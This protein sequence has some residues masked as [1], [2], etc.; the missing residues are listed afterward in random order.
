MGGLLQQP[1]SVRTNLQLYFRFL[2]PR[3]P[4]QV[5]D[6]EL[7]GLETEHRAHTAR[8]V[9]MQS[10]LADLSLFVMILR[11][12]KQTVNV[13]KTFAMGKA[14]SGINVPLLLTPSKAGNH[15]HGC[16]LMSF[17]VGLHLPRLRGRNQVPLLSSMDPGTKGMASSEK[18][19]HLVGFYPGR[20]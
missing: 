20:K 9:Q 6:A 3:E 1:V 10:S 5:K 15:C 4:E 12:G 2:S 19:G 8:L 13:N 17:Q 16:L 11:P 14:F 7:A 18:Q